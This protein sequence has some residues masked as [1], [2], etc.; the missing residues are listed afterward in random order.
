MEIIF[1]FRSA[2]IEAFLRI[3][4]LRCSKLPLKVA[5]PLPFNAAEV[6]AGI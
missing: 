4:L 3:C 2:A 5:H 1:T 6:A